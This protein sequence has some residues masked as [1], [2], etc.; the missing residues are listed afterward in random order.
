[1]NGWADM[2]GAQVARKPVVRLISKQWPTMDQTKLAAKVRALLRDGAMLTGKDIAASLRENI[3]DV[4]TL[5]GCMS[6]R[7][8]VVRVSSYRSRWKLP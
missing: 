8:E 2:W 5:L 7:G 1:M 6:R 3:Y 4:G